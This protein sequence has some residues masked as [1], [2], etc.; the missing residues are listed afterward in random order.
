MRTVTNFSYQIQSIARPVTMGIALIALVSGC[1]SSPG[2]RPSIWP[3][4]KVDSTTATANTTAAVGGALAS[5]TKTVKGQFASMSTAVS[6]AYDKAKTA[7]TTPFSSTATNTS[8]PSSVLGKQPTITPELNVAQGNFFEAQGNYT[9]AMDSY[10]K[11]LEAEPKNPSALMSMAKL[12]DRQN[13]T[14]KA[15][16]FYQKAIVVAPSAAVFADLGNLYARNQN[17]SM[18]KEQFQKAVNLEPKNKSH[19]SALAGTLLD[20]G[21]P[22]AALDEL[23]QVESPA[24]ANYQMAYLHFTRKNIPAT[25]QFLS[26]ALQ[27][28]PNLKPA[29]D[30]M[31]SM[32]SAQSIS[33]L[34]QQGQQFG[35]QATGIY[36]Q[37]GAVA[38]GVQNLWNNQ[39]AHPSGV[40]QSLPANVSGTAGGVTTPASYSANPQ[41][42]MTNANGF[43]RR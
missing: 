23:R 36:Q 9:K 3:T 13:S 8:D 1:T 12:Y 34:A 26:S 35:N 21:N 4:R 15:I 24:M 7:I 37:A 19:R 30:L 2:S 38:N 33:Q 18:A 41:S 17:L 5:T 43:I 25:Q 31:A 27:I 11:A 14:E 16:E 28:D 22:D 10:S 29:R 6:S 20:S 39:P 40:P 32:G 42:A